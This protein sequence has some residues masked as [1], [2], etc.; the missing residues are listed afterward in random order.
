MPKD[1]R[2]LGPWWDWPNRS[3]NGPYHPEWLS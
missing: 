2:L 1:I 3:M